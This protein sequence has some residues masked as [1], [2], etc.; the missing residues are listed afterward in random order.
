M[1]DNSPVATYRPRVWISEITFSDGTKVSLAKD[2][3]VILVG[4]S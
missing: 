3:V 1:A 2:D 4:P